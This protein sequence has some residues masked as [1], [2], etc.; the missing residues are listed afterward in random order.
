M[1]RYE[2]IKAGYVLEIQ[3]GIKTHLVMV[4]P[5]SYGKLCISSKDMWCYLD[6][7]KNE[8]LTYGD[9]KIVKVYGFCSSNMD[10][11]RVSTYGR[12][13]LWERTEL[14]LEQKISNI[15]DCSNVTCPSDK[16]CD[17]CTAQRLL[18]HFDIKE[19]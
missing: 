10:A 4:C 6:E 9:T 3:E 12:K 13:L 8:R 2:D 16:D 7:Y 15:L 11:R 14:T 5:T 19:K 1:F 17:I 18:K